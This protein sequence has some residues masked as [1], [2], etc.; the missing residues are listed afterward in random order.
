MICPKCG[1]EYRDGFVSC[2]DCGVPLEPSRLNQR[3]ATA[4]PEASATPPRSAYAGIPP[5]FAPPL[6]LVTVFRSGSAP[7]V[8]VAESLL[9]SAGIEYMSRGGDVQSLFGIGGIGGIN[10]VTGPVLI[11]VRREDAR[12]AEELLEHLASGEFDEDVGFDWE[13]DEV[14]ADDG[15][16][17]DEEPG[18]E[19]QDDIWNPRENE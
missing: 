11:Q 3:Q 13:D 2:K 16:S 12:D 19:W 10:L 7:Q 4:P 15:G 5:E 14:E 8:M 1:A 6:E 9:R 18:A 17:P